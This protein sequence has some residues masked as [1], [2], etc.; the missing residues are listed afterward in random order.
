M[1]LVLLVGCGQRGGDGDITISSEMGQKEKDCGVDPITGAEG[2]HLYAQHLSCAKAEEV[3]KAVP[4]SNC[5]FSRDPVC[6]VQGFTCRR[7]LEE[8][9]RV[10]V[11]TCS[12]GR[13]RAASKAYTLKY[14]NQF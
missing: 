7:R 6:Q 2:T 4:V 9:A 10:S 8:R 1:A 5:N 11:I 12:K 14:Y 13:K 3:V